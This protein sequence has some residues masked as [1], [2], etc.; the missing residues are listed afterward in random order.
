MVE[1]SVDIPETV[2]DFG[3]GYLE[4][5]KTYYDTV[6][7]RVRSGSE[8]ALWLNKESGLVG[9]RHGQ[10][11]DAPSVSIDARSKLGENAALSVKCDQGPQAGVVC[12]GVEDAGDWITVTIRYGLHV[13]WEVEPDTY[14]STQA[15]SISPI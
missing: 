2:V 13:S 6:T 1:M 15:V 14:R 9:E 11:M 12:R 8:W 7:V 10:V 4:P 5:G 3:G